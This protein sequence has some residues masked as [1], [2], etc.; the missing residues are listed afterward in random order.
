MTAG[1]TLAQPLNL[2][3]GIA[4]TAEQ[5]ASLTS[6][7]VWLVQQD[8]TLADGSTQKVL[9]PQVYA[10]ARTGD[11]AANGALLGGEGSSVISGNIVNITTTGD[12]T[13]STATLQG[14]ELVSRNATNV[15][16]LAGRIEGK[17]V[18]LSAT[19]DIE[20]IGGAVIAQQSGYGR[21]GRAERPWPA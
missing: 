15:R 11:L 5:V 6:D 3:V 17:A 20:I 2:R 21:S 4:L 19:Q 8:V 13:N 14:R 10:V 16:N 18:V 7:I 12:I 1:V 9:V